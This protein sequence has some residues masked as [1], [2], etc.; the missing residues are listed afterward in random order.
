MFRED[1]L[2]HR[3]FACITGLA[4]TIAKEN[5]LEPSGILFGI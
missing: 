2:L 3:H 1:C 5:G 4:F